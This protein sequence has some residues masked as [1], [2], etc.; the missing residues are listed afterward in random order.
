M[1]KFPYSELKGKWS[2][3]YGVLKKDLLEL[4]RSREIAEED[5]DDCVARY[6]LATFSSARRTQG[7]ISKGFC[8]EM[9]PK[10]EEQGV[11][12]CSAT[13]EEDRRLWIEEVERSISMF[14]RNT[15]FF[16]T[17]DGHRSEQVAGYRHARA[18]T[19]TSNDKPRLPRTV[20]SPE[21]KNEIARLKLVRSVSSKITR[22]ALQRDKAKS[23]NGDAPPNRSLPETGS[24]IASKSRK[25]SAEHP[26]NNV[27]PSR[28][29]RPIPG[30]QAHRRRASS[31]TGLSDSFHDHPFDVTELD[32]LEFTGTNSTDFYDL[33]SDDEEL[34]Q[35]VNLSTDPERFLI[36][37]EDSDSENESF[38]VRFVESEPQDCH[39]LLEEFSCTIGAV[40]LKPYITIESVEFSQTIRSTSVGYSVRREESVHW[41]EQRYYLIPPAC[42][43]DV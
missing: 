35:C 32:E 27:Q 34:V 14:S 31:C 4:Y 12:L 13:D 19:I 5:P 36:E 16:A 10:Q 11:L 39:S 1:V 7:G 33:S 30:L 15:S 21:S 6:D 9:E 38:L 8:F 17:P 26:Y 43:I 28:A 24:A 3:L 42:N 22:M 20:S 23:G 2:K 37:L 29:K 25:G 18:I 41:E 40:E